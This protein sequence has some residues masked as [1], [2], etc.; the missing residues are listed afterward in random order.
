[1]VPREEGD[2]GEGEVARGRDAIGV[3]IIMDPTTE[4]S[5]TSCRELHERRSY[6]RIYVHACMCAGARTCTC[7]YIYVCTHTPERERE[8]TCWTTC[9]RDVLFRSATSGPW[10]LPFNDYK[11]VGIPVTPSFITTYRSP[12]VQTTRSSSHN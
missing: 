4:K 8:K 6:V 7:M 12:P 9:S 10:R 3:H 2:G 5:E 11:R 1:M